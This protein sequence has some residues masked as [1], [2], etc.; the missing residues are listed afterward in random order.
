MCCHHDCSVHEM[1]VKMEERE[2][3]WKG[4]K[5][6]KEKLHF[7]FFQNISTMNIFLISYVHG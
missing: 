3:G 2:I 4:K 7:T 5:K 6:K 1:K